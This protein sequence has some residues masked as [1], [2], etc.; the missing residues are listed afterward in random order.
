MKCVAVA[1]LSLLSLGHSAPV[2]SCDSLVK[3]KTIS[4]ED[5]LGRWLYIGGSS[6]LPGSRSLGHLL[7]S[8]WLDITAT[9]QSNILNLVQTQRIYGDC[10]SLTYNVTFEN[11]TMLIEQP[12]YLKEVYL[13]TDCSDCLVVHEE[14][15]SGKD[16]FTSL[17]LFSRRKSV[18]P[19]ALEM[20]KKQAECLHM[21]SPIMIEPNY[22]ICPDNI[23]PSEG[24]SAFSSLLEAKMGHRVARLL[25]SLFDMFVN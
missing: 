25:D 23:L 17:L 16:T 19:D 13:K 14:V 6:D 22:E 9:T 12:F 18:S 21:P 3:P 4:N 7:T 20:L 5:M 2:S 24:L 1:L 8:A 11:S 15:V 10:S